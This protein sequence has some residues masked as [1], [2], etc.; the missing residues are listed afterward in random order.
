M[1]EN[2]NGSLNATLYTAG[3][4][5]KN[6]KRRLLYLSL[7]TTLSERCDAATF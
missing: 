6:L 1:T 3:I 2:G 4:R 7:N 5:Q